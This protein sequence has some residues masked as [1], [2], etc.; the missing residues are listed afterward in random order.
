MRGVKPGIDTG[1]GILM[2]E[3]LSA[4]KKYLFNKVQFIIRI[5]ERK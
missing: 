4:Y 3:Y 1:Q 2:Q 5:S